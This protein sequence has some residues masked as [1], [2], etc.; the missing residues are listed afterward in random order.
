M[1][2]KHRER[3]ENLSESED[4]KNQDVPNEEMEEDKQKCKCDEG[5]SCTDDCKCGEDCDC[6]KGDNK[7]CGHCHCH[8]SL[9]NDQCECDCC[10]ENHEEESSKKDLASEYLNMA[11]QIQADF[12]NFRRH[13]IDDIKKSRIEGQESVI[14]VFL[15][16]LDTFKEAK[17]SI[18]DENVLKGVQMIEDKIQDALKSL[19]VEKIASVGEKF[20]PHLHHVIAVMKDSEKDND[21]ILDEYQAGYK[22][23]DKVIRYAMVLVNKKE[24]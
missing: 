23:N 17:K 19:G 4:V 22:F 5:C 1:R 15:P 11:R 18:N 6:H 14:E 2:G 21:I 8:D 13:A 7:D 20:N 16:C 10:E 3:E 12:E 24:D 9:Q